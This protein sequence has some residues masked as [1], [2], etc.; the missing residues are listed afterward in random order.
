M[1]SIRLDSLTLS[2][3]K[4][5]KSFTLT[6]GGHDM[7]VYG[8]NATGKTTLFDAW[9]WLLF[10]KDS[11]NRA[12]FEIKTLQPDG[13][14]RHNLE[15]GVE[16]AL[17][18]DGETVTLRKVYSEKWTKRK[19]SRRASFTGH[20]TDHFVDGV[21]VTKKEYAERVAGIVDES[22]ARLLTDPAYFNEGMHWQ[23]RRSLLLNVCGDVTDAD[24]IG[25][26][27]SLAD[28]PDLLG[29]RTLD[30]HRK[31]IL[32][33]R[34]EINEQLERI[35]VRIDEATRGMPEQPSI[36][37]SKAEDALSEAKARR[38]GLEE[39]KA[40]LQ[41]GGEVAERWARVRELEGRMHD[42]TRE[43]T[44][45][46][47]RDIEAARV[48]RDAA[49]SKLDAA[50]RE[51]ARLQ[52]ATLDANDELERL[53]ERV[54]E[55][56][57]QWTQENAVIFRHDAADTCPVCHQALPEDQV[58]G[59]HDEALAQFNERKAQRLEGIQAEGKELAARAAKIESQLVDLADAIAQTVAELEALEPAVA[60]LARKVEALQASKPDPAKVPG[61]A[62]LLEEKDA[63]L[64]TIED[65]RGGNAEALE[66]LREQAS[67]ADAA[68]TEAQAALAAFEQRDRAEARIA[69]LAEQE[70][71]LAAEFEDLE[72]QLH[73]ADE[74][75]RA[76][77][78]LLEARINAK[79]ELARF[80][81]FAEQVNGGLAET[82]TTT[83]QGV[84]YD[85][86]NHGARIN[87][88]LDIV[89]T[90]QDHYGV[91]PPTWVDQA[92][93]VTRLIDMPCQ[94]ITLTVS[95]QD[96]ALRVETLKEVAA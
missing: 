43:A 13:E 81:L 46:V 88:G 44:A 53:Q 79:F 15:H 34:K 47:D 60:N 39:Q 62:A 80:K 29:K 59:A 95:A 31:V 2:N 65:L 49:M 41:A 24:V 32:A 78:R 71:R 68:I 28:L 75:T 77:V 42:L 89:R 33:R 48:E 16:A 45:R 92:E 84:P 26:D 20:T 38:G 69:E 6:A 11:G 82:C 17:T 74:F 25:S 37:R 70:K 30:E 86:L 23:E 85:N 4:G 14:A 67:K 72:R 90:L 52:G 94:T 63:L 87:V 19:G 57:A 96:R 21:P 91:H 5:V 61:H 50:K 56:R 93:A 35:P 9:V 73:L 10:D 66:Q 7:R 51:H 1:S 3:F 40:R 18:V 76:K 8:D 12:N 55:K 27:A 36:T 54:Q 22:V 64:A 83:F 58:R